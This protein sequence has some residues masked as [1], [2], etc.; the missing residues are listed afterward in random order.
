MLCK[1]GR[2]QFF[3][4]SLALNCVYSPVKCCVSKQYYPHETLLVMLPKYKD[5]A[6]AVCV[7]MRH[8]HL[9]DIRTCC[10]VLCDPLV[11]EQLTRKAFMRLFSYNIYPL[12]AQ[13]ISQFLGQ[14]L[15]LLLLYTYQVFESNQ[16]PDAFVIKIKDI[17]EC[18]KLVIPA[19]KI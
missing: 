12:L 5:K 7:V 2:M 14:L 18:S 15:V 9:G 4:A 16:F 10:W 6:V 3:K 19:I 11:I 17:Q 1:I 13:G 8:W